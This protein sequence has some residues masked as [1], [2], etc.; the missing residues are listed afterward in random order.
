M[1][2]LWLWLCVLLQVSWTFPMYSRKAPGH[3]AIHSKLGRPG[4]VETNNFIKKPRS[5]NQN[6]ERIENMLERLAA[7]RVS[8]GQDSLKYHRTQC[9]HMNQSWTHWQDFTNNQ[10]PGSVYMFRV[11]TGPLQPTFP[12]RNLFQYITRIYRCCKL[13]LN[14]PK[15][16]GLQGTLEDGGKEIALYMD[17]DIFG[18][19]VRRAE[20]H[21]EV[22]A[23][24]LVTVIPAL[25][26]NGVTHSR[27]LQLRSGHIIDLALD[28]MFLL[29]AL[30]EK[31]MEA[32]IL[33][34]VTELSLTLHCIKD[35]LHVPCS[36]H[37]V[38]LLHA[39][40]IALQ[41]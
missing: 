37:R 28:I 25:S 22:L 1:S 31:D 26:I 24:E 39:P 12:Q 18:L 8:K 15:I 40:F 21:L 3:M 27:F 9:N 35:D 38:S 19:S 11:F 30:K 17:S 29:Q 7:D 34:D 4:N 23:D 14:C 33:E 32:M 36:R 20:L 16:K 10:D 41:Y 2:A 6:R 5:E 13:R